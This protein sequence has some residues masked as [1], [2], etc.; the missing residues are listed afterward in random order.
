MMDGEQT[1]NGDEAT[2]SAAN[3]ENEALK[4]KKRIEAM[5]QLKEQQEQGR[6]LSTEAQQQPL[7]RYSS[8][9]KWISNTLA[10]RKVGL[11]E[12]GNALLNC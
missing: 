6:Q 10:K 12:S 1:A 7:P 11:V 5:R 8:I 9:N 2:L 3:L 4:R